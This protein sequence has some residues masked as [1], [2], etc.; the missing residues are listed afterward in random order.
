MKFRPVLLTA[1]VAAP[2]L[3]G[4]LPLLAQPDPSG[5]LDRVPAAV[6]NLDEPTKVKG[7]NGKQQTVAAGRQLAADLSKDDGDNFDWRLTDRADAR[8]GLRDGTY[9]AIVTIPEGFSETVSSTSGKHPERAELRVRSNDANSYLA[10]QIADSLATASAE[11]LGDTVSEQYLET[12]YTGFNDLHKQTGKVARGADDLATG[13]TDLSKGAA[14]AG[15]GADQVADGLG[16]LERGAGELANGTDQLASGT[17]DLSNGMTELRE[18]TGAL[19]DQTSKLAAGSADVANGARQLSGGTSDVAAGNRELSAALDKLAEACT[20]SALPPYC[21]Q[22]ER[23]QQSSHRLA[24]GAEQNSDGA[25]RLAAGAKQVA[26]GNLQF[27]DSVPRLGTGIKRAANGADRLASGADE[28]NAGAGALA[29]HLT[30]AKTGARQVAD[31]TAELAAGSNDLADGSGN[32][33]GGLRDGAKSVPT[34]NKDQRKQSAAVVSEPISTTLDRAN[35]GSLADSL[36]PVVLPIALWIGVLAICFV[37]APISRTALPTT[38][39]S[40]RIAVRG[41]GRIAALA[42]AQAIALVVAVDLLGVEVANPLAATG[43]A[44]A[45]AVSFAALHQWLITAFDRVGVLVS[46]AVLVL[47]A[48]AV[49]W[50]LFAGTAAGLSGLAPFL[51]ATYAADG[52]RV[53][54]LGVGDV[55]SAWSAVVMLVV[56]GLA[57]FALTVQTIRRRRGLSVATGPMPVA[58]GAPSAGLE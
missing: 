1:I 26:R 52:L 6:V 34:Y 55:A 15:D 58:S 56:L 45:A 22:V 47:Q 48:A 19:P 53:P 32:L 8:D 25:A 14:K 30:D 13:A 18:Q 37:V 24:D 10:G 3:L 28:V 21:E 51:P 43:I 9:A 29:E 44:V 35:A 36:A 33:A 27:A 17:R 49:G 16:E 42:A 40:W 46:L 5:D 41:L 38:L 2:V 12:V 50:F 57:G 31:G 11:S 39:P 7:A 23:V 4:A 54:M 20:T